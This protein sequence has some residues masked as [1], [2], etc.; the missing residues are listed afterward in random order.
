MLIQD[1]ERKGSRERGI[2]R[3]LGSVP[4]Q[5]RKQR[6]QWRTNCL[7]CSLPHASTLVWKPTTRC[8]RTGCRW[9]PLW[10]GRSSGTMVTSL[11]LFP[12]SHPSISPSPLPTTDWGT[13]ASLC[14]CHHMLLAIVHS[15]SCPLAFNSRFSPT[16]ADPSTIPTLPGCS[17]HSACFRTLAS[18]T[19]PMWSYLKS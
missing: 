6:C 9:P 3:L 4:G 2:E 15:C 8:M 16:H 10:T 11:A 7:L 12:T 1:K 18:S 19:L 13:S 5:D 14:H 17:R